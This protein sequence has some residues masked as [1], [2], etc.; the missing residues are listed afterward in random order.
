MRVEHYADSIQLSTSSNKVFPRVD[1]FHLLAQEEHGT[2][3]VRLVW[4]NEHRQV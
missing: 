3:L 1:R 2:K 4:D